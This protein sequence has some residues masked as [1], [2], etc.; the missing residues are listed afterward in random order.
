MFN[1]EEDFVQNTPKS[2]I[3]KSVSL[4]AP[5]DII[6]RNEATLT[7][8]IKKLAALIV[9]LGFGGHEKIAQQIGESACQI[10]E[11]H[12]HAV[13][14]GEFDQSS[15]A[16]NEMDNLILRAESALSSVKKKPVNF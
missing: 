12:A 6:Q 8:K 1:G 3:R 9:D 4:S 14:K 5:S 7:S 2:P 15:K 11:A 16:L 13:I 10:E